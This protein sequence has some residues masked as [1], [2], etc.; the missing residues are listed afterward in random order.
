MN[1]V[2]LDSGDTYMNFCTT[3]IDMR[4]L[5]LGYR[6]NRISED[7]S[8]REASETEP[9]IPDTDI[10]GD[11]SA[12]VSVVRRLSNHSLKHRS[13]IQGFKLDE[14]PAIHFDGILSDMRSRHYDIPVIDFANIP[15]MRTMLGDDVACYRLLTTDVSPKD[16][17]HNGLI[18][19]SNT[20]IRL[21]ASVGMLSDSTM[22]VEVA[23]SGGLLQWPYFYDTSLINSIVGIFHSEDDHNLE[24]DGN[25]GEE[26]DITAWMYINVVVSDTEIFIPVIDIDIASRL[27]EE[28]WRPDNIEPRNNFEKVADRILA[29][30]LVHSADEAGVLSLEDRGL[31]LDVSLMRCC[32]ASGGDGELS[33]KADLVDVSALIRDP[34][35]RVH[36]VIQPVSASLNLRMQQPEAS[37]RH[38]L[39]RLNHAA[40]IIQRHWRR[41]YLLHKTAEALQEENV[42]HEQAHGKVDGQWKLVE[43]LALDVAT[44]RT[45]ELL[46]DYYSGKGEKGVFSQILFKAL[47]VQSIHL[48]VGIFTCRL[49]FSH[50]SFWKS[51]IDGLSEMSKLVSGVEP[52]LE[53]QDFRPKGLKMAASF[54]RLALVL[55]NDKPETFGAPDVLHVSLSDGE[56]ALD[57]ASLL[58]D[59]PPNAVGNVSVTLFSSFLNSGSSKWESL[60]SPWPVRAEIVDSNGSGFASDRKMCV[61]FLVC[62]YLWKHISNDICDYLQS[63]LAHV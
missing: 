25:T 51:A 37:E 12:G 44:P 49:A 13:S 15:M 53:E 3:S 43:K 56:C 1:T 23:L 2:N 7:I 18:P 31:S 38:E 8:V 27:I 46:D 20:N 29:T 11:A 59:R 34:K 10:D 28:L 47:S 40:S 63:L 21:E 9:E 54:E 55:C 32:I 61:C 41:Y 48:K 14:A 19:G 30:L 5:R 35:A 6:L 24:D 60:L 39:K 57:T 58:P 17:G 45:R 26:L 33:V 22:A 52:V 50:V 36:T 42:A 4:D 62:D 16:R